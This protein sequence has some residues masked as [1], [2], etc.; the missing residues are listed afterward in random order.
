MFDVLFLTADDG[1]WLR[2]PNFIPSRDPAH[3]TGGSVS[4]QRP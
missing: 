4:A 2:V 1:W 3:W